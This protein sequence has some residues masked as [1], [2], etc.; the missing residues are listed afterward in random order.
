MEGRQLVFA[1]GMKAGKGQLLSKREFN[2]ASLLLDAR[3]LCRVN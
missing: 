2:N 3:G 1:Q